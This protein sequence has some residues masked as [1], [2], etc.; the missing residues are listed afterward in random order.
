MG[1]E[2][3]LHRELL[4]VHVL[5]VVVVDEG[6]DVRRAGHVVLDL[7]GEGPE[8]VAHCLVINHIINC[9]QELRITTVPSPKIS[10]HG[11]TIKSKKEENT[12][13][14]NKSSKIP[15]RSRISNK[16]KLYN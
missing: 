16:I 2:G 3:L 12:K 9:S 10:Y 11:K 15:D 6:L 8:I 14:W 4:Q 1:L 13:D 7:L 5:H